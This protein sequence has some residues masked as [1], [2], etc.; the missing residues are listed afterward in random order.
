MPS[1]VRSLN[2]LSR[3]NYTNG[4]AQTNGHTFLARPLDTKPCHALNAPEVCATFG[5]APCHALLRPPQGA[6]FPLAFALAFGLGLGFAFAF[7]FGYCAY[8]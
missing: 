5:H 4:H 3:V 8:V 2:L 1:C 7:A 6:A